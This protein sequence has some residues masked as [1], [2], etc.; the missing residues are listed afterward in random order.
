LILA[1]KKWF[2]TKLG[3]LFENP[4][5]ALTK[6][7]F[8]ITGTTNINTIKLDCLQLQRDQQWLSLLAMK[9]LKNIGVSTW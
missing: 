1:F 2:E 7:I 5:P 8:D 3:Q 6:I 4:W 9:Q